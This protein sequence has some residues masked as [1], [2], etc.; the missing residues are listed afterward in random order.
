MPLFVSPR[1]S[2]EGQESILKETECTLFLSTPD[3]HRCFED[4]QKVAPNT[5]IVEVPR[6]LDLLDPSHRPPHYDGRHRRDGSA[7]SLILHTSGSTGEWYPSAN[8]IPQVVNEH[9]RPSQ[10][11]SSDRRW[12]ELG[13][14]AS[15][16]GSRARSS[17]H[18]EAIS[19]RQKADARCRALLPRNGH[20]G[21][22]PIA[23]V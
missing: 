14:R 23:D 1:N 4:I 16:P 18:H 15:K 19:C 13:I 7:N 12:P 20:R 9:G 2:P 8:C 21:R 10:G 6:L 17:E 3:R 11:R 22:T 5:Q